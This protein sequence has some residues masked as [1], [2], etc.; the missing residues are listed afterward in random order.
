MALQNQTSIECEMF[1]KL[2]QFQGTENFEVHN[3]ALCASKIK[4][5]DQLFNSCKCQNLMCYNFEVFQ[6]H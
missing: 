5:S 3:L 6:W 2:D 4:I 1:I